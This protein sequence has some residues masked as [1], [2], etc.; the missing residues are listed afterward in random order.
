[1]ASLDVLFINQG[2][3]AHFLCLFKE[4]RTT[5]A[6]EFRSINAR[7]ADKLVDAE[8]MYFFLK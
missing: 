4:G 3:R 6:E 1:M 8:Y 5:R 7:F 2:V